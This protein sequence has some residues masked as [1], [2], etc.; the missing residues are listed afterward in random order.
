MSP[1]KRSQTKKSRSTKR[2][3]DKKNR[4]FNRELSW[5]EFDDRVL[6]QALNPS[7]PLAERLK[8]LAIVSSNL[9]ENFMIRVAGLMHR[10]AAGVRRRDPSGLTPTQQL[11]LYAKRAHRLVEEQTGGIRDAFE[12][13]RRF[14]VA[15]LEIDEWSPDQRN[16]CSSFFHDEIQPLI[17]PLATWRLDDILLVPGLKTCVAA[18]LADAEEPP[19]GRGGKN[20][21][22]RE[23]FIV[24]CPL[25]G[26]LPRFISLPCEDGTALALTEDILV[27]NIGE[28]YPETEV[29]AACTFRVTRDAD[30]AIADDDA[31][32]LLE[33]VEEAVLQRRRRMAVRLQIREGADRHLKRWLVQWL[34]LKPDNVY[35]TAG[36]IDPTCLFE[37]AAHPD[38]ETARNPEWPPQ[39]PRA[40]VGVEDLFEAIR[41]RDILLSHPYESFDPVVRLIEQAAEDRDVLAIKQCLYRTSGDS[42]VVSALEQAAERGKEVTVLVELKARFDESRN[43][44]W[45]RRLEDAGCNVIYGIAGY[46]THSK[47]L[48][49]VRRES[50]RIR[51]YAHLAT[52]NYNDKTARLYCDLGMMTADPELTMDVAAFFN[53]LTGYSESVGWSKLLVAPT[54]LRRRFLEM[55]DREI[56][57]STDTSPGLIMAKVNSLE[58]PQIIEKLYDAS[59]A[60]VRVLLNVRGICCLRPGVKGLSENI[61]VTSIVDRFLEHARIFYFQNGGRDEVYLGSADWMVRN[62]SRRLELAF[63]VSQPDL[64]RRVIRMLETYFADNVSA[65]ELEP[66]GQYKRVAGKP[67]V[68]S[69]EV[70]F[71]EA[72]DAYQTA[73]RVPRQF[74]PLRSPREK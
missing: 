49:I 39:P 33:A 30:V 23:P 71:Q 47:A 1:K 73:V 74:K 29:R 64:A 59:K 67:P 34:Q 61:R 58:D 15:V 35:E 25:P 63:P 4:F 18:L 42:P 60:G 3:T 32:D 28:L 37:L 68:R 66:D 62:L 9:D 54:D 46:K 7:N 41:D 27:D 2:N 20:P 14:N 44:V 12:E 70:L 55:I 56:Q 10:Q 36:P 52:G 19:L 57:V 43:V 50:G 6:R 40:L 65:W 8:F 38:L 69:Q 51:R 16:Y 24:L 11:A 48:L 21:L 22:K 72:V 45:A 5:L 13:L 17:T 26:G 31:E 53:L